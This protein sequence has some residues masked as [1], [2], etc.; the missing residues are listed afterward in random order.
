MISSTTAS[1]AFQLKEK[2]KGRSFYTFTIFSRKTLLSEFCMNCNEKM[3]LKVHVSAVPFAGLGW[4]ALTRALGMH[5]A[6]CILQTADRGQGI[7]KHSQITAPCCWTDTSPCTSYISWVKSQEWHPGPMLREYRCED[8][9]YGFIRF[10]QR[11]IQFLPLLPD[12]S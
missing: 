4:G 5:T 11:Y 2:R 1:S 10:L 3:E 9:F 8:L 12:K 6:H 7:S